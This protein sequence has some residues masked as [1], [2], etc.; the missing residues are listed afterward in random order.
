LGSLTEELKQA[1]ARTLALVSRRAEV[2]KQMGADGARHRRSVEYLVCAEELRKQRRPMARVEAMLALADESLGPVQALKGLLSL[3]R[4]RVSEALTC[5]EKA[6]GL[7]PWEAR[8]WYVRGRV[9]LE[10]L[11]LGATADLE[12]AARLSKEKDAEVLTALGEAQLAAGDKEA[13][14]QTL[15]KALH[16]QPADKAI[17]DL[18][19][20]SDGESRTN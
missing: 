4:G 16:L 1:R 17:Q 3:E 15:R 11:A 19:R 9:R 2:L 6:I 10:R 5:A 18:L 8:A 20:R 12:R 7:S 14:R 13:A